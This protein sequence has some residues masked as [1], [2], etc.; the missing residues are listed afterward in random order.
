MK[1]SLITVTLVALTT[2][3]FA[4]AAN[5][6]TPWVDHRQ[7]N[8]AKRIWHGIANGSLTPRETAGLLRGQ[9][10][11]RAM[12]RRFKSDGVVTP[13]ERVRLHRQLNRQNRR[14]WRKKHN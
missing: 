14:I 6:Q 13:R 7:G 2:G 9:V 8:Q 3:I 5:A 10:R 4:S 12:E 11:S 1:K